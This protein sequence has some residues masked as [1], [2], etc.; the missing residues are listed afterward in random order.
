MI[1][2]KYEEMIVIPKKEKDVFIVT[3]VTDYEKKEYTNKVLNSKGT[4]IFKEFDKIEPIEYNSSDIT[5]DKNVLKCYKNGKIKSK[6]YYTGNRKTGIWQYYHENGKIKTEV[7]FN[8]LSKDEEAI[9]KTYDEKGIIIS[10]GKVVNG[11]MVDV[12]TYY[13][14][15]GRKLN[16]YDLTKGVIV[17]YSEKGKVI[18]KVS[19]KALLNRLEEIMVEVNNDRARA[20]EE[21]N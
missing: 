16:T 3:E 6:E 11:E 19:E 14:E 4:Q 12:W 21:K 13:D 1:P 15:M 10:S 8:A 7:M 9:V 2:N 17:T 18:L 5:Y 20:N